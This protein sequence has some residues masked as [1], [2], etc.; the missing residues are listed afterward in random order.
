MTQDELIA[1]LERY[2]KQLSG[3]LS[4]FVKTRDS[5]SIAPEDQARFKEFGV[6]LIDLLR[7]EFTDALHHAIVT[8]D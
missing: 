5:I 3:I 2:S 6:E 4:R 7:D 1:T 8:A